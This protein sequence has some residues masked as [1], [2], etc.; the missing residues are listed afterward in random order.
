VSG[1]LEPVK[2]R[3]VTMLE[4]EAHIDDWCANYAYPKKISPE[5]I[6][7][8]RWRSPLLN[9]FE[10]TSDMKNSPTP[11]NWSSV[12]EMMTWDLDPELEYECF[13]GA[14]GEGATGEFMSFRRIW[15]SKPN[16]DAIL[17]NPR[18]AALPADGVDQLSTLYAVSVGLANRATID[19]FD[20][21]SIY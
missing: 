13:A 18:T 8:L 3:M 12:A 6:A 17:L 1:I 21:I 2:G 4:V 14:V 9:K 20:R 19:N 16:I 15:R 7:F 10:P 5:L 11:R